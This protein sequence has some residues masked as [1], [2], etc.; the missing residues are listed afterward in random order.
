MTEP[1]A[2]LGWY[3]KLLLRYV[4]RGPYL[5]VGRDGRLLRL[6]AER[7]P[8]YGLVPD[9]ETAA[10]VRA[11]APGCPVHL[12]P[13]DLAPASVRG[14]A[15]FS[16]L[17]GRTADGAL[18]A[19]WW[20]I[21]VPGGRAVVLVPDPEGRGATLRNEWRPGERP[22]SPTHEDWRK[23]LIEAGFIVFRE[24]SDGL[25]RGPYGRFPTALDPRTIPARTQRLLGTLF[26]NSGEGD[27]S[28]FVVEKPA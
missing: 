26:L 4:G 19:E 17:T 22:A 13:R 6:L 8:A 2:P 11:E 27:N 25:S 24:G 18:V 21:L 5:E 28:V 23:L 16:A 3:L 15:A 7:G 10:R 9:E 12:D 14:I 20:R 1:L